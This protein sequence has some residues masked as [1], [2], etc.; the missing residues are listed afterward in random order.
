MKYSYFVVEGIHDAA[1]I[2]K[3]LK[4]FRFKP[5]SQIDQV[6]PFWKKIIP[7][8]FP[9]QGDL[10][11]RMP[12]PHFFQTLEHSVAIQ[13]AG[14]DSKLY[15]TLSGTLA[16]IGIDELFSIGIFCD[17]DDSQAKSKY[18]RHFSHIREHIEEDTL[19][20]I[21]LSL[22][23]GEVVKVSENINLG[24]YIFPNNHDKGVLEHLLIDGARTSYNDLLERATHYIENVDS[25]FKEKWKPY[26]ALKATVGTIANVL[27]PGKSNQ[28][29]IQDNDWITEE[30]IQAS[31]GLTLLKKFIKQLLELD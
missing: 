16:N 13:Y 21:L 11:K 14:G 12:A 28:V 29:S 23:I 7:L 9:Y 27:K 30:S 10:N 22:T 2:G 17:A 31:S 20:E 8:K 15:S 19:K 3:L 5:I 6:D 4:G 1:A 18:Q 24:V 25:Q 26:D